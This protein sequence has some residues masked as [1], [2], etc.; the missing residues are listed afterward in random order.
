GGSTLRP[1][2]H[3]RD[4]LHTERASA[5][6]PSLPYKDT[7]EGAA[8]PRLM[9]WDGIGGGGGVLNLRKNGPRSI[10]ASD[11]GRHQPSVRCSDPWAGMDTTIS[12]AIVAPPFLGYG[13]DSATQG[14]D[15][16]LLG[17]NKEPGCGKDDFDA[18]RD[19]G[20]NGGMGGGDGMEHTVPRSAAA[21]APVM[22]VDDFISSGPFDPSGSIAPSATAIK[23]PDGEAPYTRKPARTTASLATAAMATAVGNGGDGGGGGGGGGS[24]GPCSP[25]KAGAPAAMTSSATH[26]TLPSPVAVQVASRRKRKT[27]G[28]GGG[29]SGKGAKDSKDGVTRGTV[30]LFHPRLY[31]SGGDCIECGNE[32]M[33]R[34]KFERLA[35]T[36]TAKWHVSIKVLPSGMTLGRWLQKHGLPVLQGRPRKRAPTAAAEEDEED[37]D[38]TEDERSGD[39]PSAPSSLTGAKDRPNAQSR[40]AAGSHSARWCRNAD[41]DADATLRPDSEQEVNQQDPAR[42]VPSAPLGRSEYGSWAHLDNG[43]DSYRPRPATPEQQEQ[44]HGE[45]RQLQLRSEN[46]ELQQQ[47]QQQQ[48]LLQQMGEQPQSQSQPQRQ[49]RQQLGL[50]SKGQQ[51]RQQLHDGQEMYGH[52]RQKEP[53]FLQQQQPL[54]PQ[55]QRPHH[56][57]HHHHRQ[58]HQLHHQQNRHHQR[59]HHE[60]Q[61]QHG[62][63]APE[64]SWT[65]RP[66]A[67]ACGSIAGGMNDAPVTLTA[68]RDGTQTVL[69][70][71]ANSHPIGFTS[72]PPA[73]AGVAFAA[74]VNDRSSD[75]AAA[76]A[77]GTDEPYVCDGK[78]GNGYHLVSW[79]GRADQVVAEAAAGNRVMLMSNLVN[80]KAVRPACDL[81]ENSQGFVDQQR[82]PDA[83]GSGGGGGGPF[84]VVNNSSP[85]PAINTAPTHMDSPSQ[86][87]HTLALQTQPP[88]RRP[89]TLSSPGPPQSPRALT[90]SSPARLLQRPSGPSSNDGLMPPA[91]APGS[92]GGGG[93]VLIDGR[94]PHVNPPTLV[95]GS[96]GCITNPD[97]RASSSN[98][99]LSRMGGIAATGP[100]VAIVT[101]SAAAT[102]TSGAGGPGGSAGGTG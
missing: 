62:H 58:H 35:G 47:Q 7:G 45:H 66:D 98:N 95:L 73:A 91:E 76:A 48:Q 3:G 63:Q 68:R 52:H 33:S 32:M 51:Q 64:V 11:A 92:G 21:T 2:P 23:G 59:Y 30:G 65:T 53:L 10:C 25:D 57:N 6:T 22:G 81:T 38:E 49:S 43:G 97:S 16:I 77:A 71:S 85:G 28:S 19:G 67:Y 70:D 27:E 83:S 100:T 46:A 78:S 5:A 29:R 86:L 75:A 88:H 1:M 72:F 17:T 93:A 96:A 14:S 26:G 9:E 56:H 24:A 36:A 13:G 41:L 80:F 79:A 101:T 84:V 82:W 94:L 12:T 8:A 60:Q 34:G 4:N 42:G 69:D 18:G 89:H 99:H 74:A 55:P 90:V 87:A 31:L 54:P 102:I 37:T 20:G 40:R 39:I 50:L 44:Q 61:S 15:S